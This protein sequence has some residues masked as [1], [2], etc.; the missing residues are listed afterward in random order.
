VRGVQ[1]LGRDCELAAVARALAEVA[2]GSTRAFGVF[3]E[4][5]LGKTALLAAAAERARAAGM[6]VLEGRG[7]EHERDVP[8]GVVVDALD[9]HVATL[10]PQR[11][12]AL[13]RDLGP[14]LPALARAPVAG[15]AERFRQHRALRELLGQ[16]GRERPLAL[17]LDDLHWA[18]EATV[19]FVLHLLRRPPRGAVLLAL[20]SRPV[21]PALRVLEAARGASGWEELTL[22]PLEREAALALLGGISDRERVLR[23]AGGNP[24]FLRELAAGGSARTLVAAVALELAALQPAPRALAQGAAVAGDRFDGELAAAAARMAPDAA[25]LDALVAADLV[26][27]TGE[28]RQF[29]FRHPLVRRA[30][31]DAVP[32]TA[33]LAAHERVAEAL[34][35]RGAPAV[36]R[37]HHVEQSARPG[38]E[39]AIALLSEAGAAAG[40]SAPATAARWY[41]AGLRLVADHDRARREQLLGGIA[42]A[43]AA[44]GRLAE[45]REALVALLELTPRL[46][47]V[48]QCAAVE[49]VL[50]RHAD[51]RARLEAALKE[52]PPDGR[53]TILLGLANAAFYTG[54][55]AAMRGWARRAAE[56]AAGDP[57]LLAEAD[58]C[59]ALG[60][61]WDGEAQIAGGMLDR[62]SER[63]RGADDCALAARPDCARVLAGSQL[64]AERYADAAD[65]AA[66]GLACARRIHQQQTLTTL[67]LY[68]AGALGNLLE[69]DAARRE[70]DA[71]EE[72]ARLQ[73]SPHELAF[74][75]WQRAIIHRYQ[76]AAAEAGRDAAEFAALA[77]ALEPN[78]IIRTGM[79]SL[80]ALR[81]DEDPERCL[82]TIAHGLDGALPTWWAALL[83][84]MV[85]CALALGRHDEARR[86]AAL[87]HERA[88]ALQ[89]PASLVRSQIAAAEVLLATGPADQAAKLAL[90]AATT[91]QQVH[92]LRDGAEA[93][94]TAGRAL[95]AAGDASRANTVLQRLAAD[96]LRGGALALSQAAAA[97]LRRLGTRPAAAARRAAHQRTGLTDREREIARLVGGGHSNKEIAAALFLSEK[98]VRNSLTRVYATLGVRGR[99]DLARRPRAADPAGR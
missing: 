50:G 71:A 32:P 66:R 63:L 91:A 44:A 51:A 72:S 15:V 90:A 81:A 16:L 92:A 68:R 22:E 20:A 8:F 78:Q 96:A 83:L 55:V 74:A 77:G 47:L 38:D 62:A 99:A 76:A 36:V 25:A 58:G 30:V 24:L 26:R 95:A 28:G 64:L 48:V 12:A 29:A 42:A 39:A 52:A 94:L 4:M 33:R 59:G 45:S 19:E 7:V 21:D 60:A 56:V 9:D 10:A 65:T 70:I 67:L 69:L 27:P 49:G 46:E 3:G 80:A 93:R 97:E 6:L 31:Y 13:E 5:G 73:R 86:W 54:D 57:L 87:A 40:P 88:T 61:L 89:L 37:A 84:T 98:T 11:L 43:L 79:C 53:G 35:H 34:E 17:L 85:R 41:A 23:Q 75:L 82:A 2:G 18:D 1:L 14:V